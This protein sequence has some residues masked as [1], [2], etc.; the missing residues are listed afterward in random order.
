MHK[1]SVFLAFFLFSLV[2]QAETPPKLFTVGVLVPLSGGASEQGKWI[3]RGLDL[4]KREIERRDGA[5]LDLHFEDTQGDTAKA[6]SA[7]KY[8]QRTEKPSVYFAWGSG[9]GLALTPLVN[10]DQIPL[11]GVATGTPLYTSPNDFTFRNFPSA[12]DEALQAVK[13]V[14][15]DLKAKRI[16]ILQIE[17]AYGE[18]AIGAFEKHAAHTGAQVVRKEVF[19]PGDSD[20][21]PQILRMKQ[22]APDVVYLASYP[23]EGGIALR[24]MKEMR[25]EAQIVATPAIAGSHTFSQLGDEIL[26][27]L[28]IISAAPVFTDF[29]QPHVASFVHRYQEA[30]GEKPDLGHY[31][32]VNAYDALHIIA[33]LLKLCASE[34]E[35]GSCLRDKLFSLKSYHGVGGVISFDRNGDV[36]KEFSV[37]QYT[38]GAFQRLDR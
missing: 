31:L 19:L 22:S 10:R 3:E 15:E 24:Q 38:N 33:P 23:H 17:N 37:Q 35:S 1:I 29:S 18:G 5:T 26:E 6:I 25:V 7:Y 36:K 30:Y 4:A 28:I 12:V 27:G 16:A 8:L 20:F 14:T 2:S 13:V 32:G 34:E 21:R 9:V 11:I